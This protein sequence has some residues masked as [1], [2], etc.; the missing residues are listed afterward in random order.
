MTMPG[1]TR[2]ERIVGYDF[3]VFVGIVVGIVASGM[4]WVERVVRGVGIAVVMTEIE[5]VS[6]IVA[7]IEIVELLQDAQIQ[8]HDDEYE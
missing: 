8:I 6:V 3:E 1:K 2:D 4:R 5:I 7:V